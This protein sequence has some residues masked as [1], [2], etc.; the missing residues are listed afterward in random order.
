MI[1]SLREMDIFHSFYVP[2]GFFIPGSTYQSTQEFYLYY[3]INPMFLRNASSAIVLSIIAI[4]AHCSVK[5]IANKKFAKQ[6]QKNVALQKFCQYK[7]VHLFRWNHL[8]QSLFVL[9][10][11]FYFA[12]SFQMSNLKDR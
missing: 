7:L 6:T 5:H 4:I 1:L 11:P 3:D 9:F 8:L 10:S 12:A 2:L